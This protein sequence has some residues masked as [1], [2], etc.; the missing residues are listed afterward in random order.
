MTPDTSYGLAITCGYD[1]NGSQE[2]DGLPT[3]EELLRGT[4]G[5]Q[6]LQR[7]SSSGGYMTG[8]SEGYVDYAIKNDCNKIASPKSRRGESKGGYIGS[9]CH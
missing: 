1:R 6:K 8:G 4:E 9:I 3:L 2:N 7:A 5:T